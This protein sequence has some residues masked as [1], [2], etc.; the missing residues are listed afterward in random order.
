MKTETRDQIIQDLNAE[1][2]DLVRAM[3]TE[4]DERDSLWE[5][6]LT[7]NIDIENLENGILFIKERNEYQQKLHIRE[8]V[9]ASNMQ[10]KE[11]V[12]SHED[13]EVRI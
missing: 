10:K 2:A 5:K 12:D 9:F 1:I 11:W 4:E 3:Q 6:I 8:R 7:I 13:S